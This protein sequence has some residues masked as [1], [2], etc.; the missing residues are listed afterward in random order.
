MDGMYGIGALAVLRARALAD[1]SISSA[2]QARNAAAAAR[3]TWV[4]QLVACAR[5]RNGIDGIGGADV[6][7][8]IRPG[9]HIPQS[10][11]CPTRATHPPGKLPENFVACARDKSY[12]G[13]KGG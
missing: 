9:P 2:R 11:Q 3:P 12:P 10:P 5:V 13:E 6:A 8:W 7:H 4:Q 1:S